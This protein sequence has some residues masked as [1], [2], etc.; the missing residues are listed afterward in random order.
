MRTARRSTRGASEMGRPARLIA[1]ASYSQGR[2]V[3]ADPAAYAALSGER[4]FLL[5]GTTALDEARPALTDGLEAAGID[6]AGVAD[7][8]DACTF[9]RID[10]LTAAARDAGS[11]DGPP[12]AVVAVGG[13]VAL[14]AGK[15]VAERT[16]AELATVPTVA[17]TDAPCSSVAVVYDA[18]GRFDGY[19]RRSRNPEA[20]VVDTGVIAAAPARFL[21]YGMGDALATRFE[22]E[23]VTRAGAAADTHAGGR[24]TRAAR[25]LAADCYRT[26]SEAGEAALSAARRDAA[27][28]ALDRVVE[29]NTLLSGLGFESGGLAAAHAFAKGFSRA[30]VDEPHGVLVA[31]GTL[32][33]LVLADREPA[34]LAEVA[35]LCRRL[36]LTAPLAELGVD[37]GQVGAVAAAACGDGTT[38]DD[39]PRAVAPA[40][41]A[42]ALRAADGLLADG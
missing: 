10:A 23:A 16:G 35:D 36:E 1:P 17:S 21:R 27:T 2:E 22:V 38:M 20:V 13:G 4:A 31:F 40:D 3:L 14:D 42:A 29:A 15:A 30:G 5:G 24:P 41:A 28:G 26:I 7:G 19:V 25:T 11:G 12:G 8:V 18:A 34:L 39:L 9:D 6:V 37:D 32:A 33:Q